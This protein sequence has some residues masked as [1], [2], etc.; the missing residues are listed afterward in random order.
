MK[1][2]LIH[3]Q[4][5]EVIK[6]KEVINNPQEFTKDFIKI[7]GL[8]FVCFVSVEDQNINDLKL[9]SRQGTEEIEA[10]ILQIT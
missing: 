3:S 5:V 6:N 7:E 8:I 1:I 10:V 4:D 9:I 2:L